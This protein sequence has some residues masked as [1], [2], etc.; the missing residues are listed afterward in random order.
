MLDSD[1]SEDLIMEEKDLTVPG[2]VT[3]QGNIYQG[4]ERQITK[5]VQDNPPLPL[6]PKSL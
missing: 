6:F 1:D 4:F 3:T 2:I 5:I